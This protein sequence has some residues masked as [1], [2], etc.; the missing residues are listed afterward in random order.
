MSMT[1][2]KVAVVSE[3]ASPL[4]A[5]GGVDAGGQNVHV[6]ALSRALARR[7]HTI[8][9]YTRRDAI[10]L[11][12]QVPLD[13]GVTVEHVPA[14]PAM[15]I[16]K[17]QLLPYMG[18]FGGYLA[19]AWAADPPDIVHAH[20]WMSGLAALDGA[21]NL[22]LPVI[23]TYH[24]LG[25]VKRRHQGAADT[26]P[27]QRIAHEWA[28]GRRCDHIIATC[29]DEVDELVAMGVPRSR[30]TVVACGVDPDHFTPDGPVAARSDR[31][32]LL[33]VGRLVARKGA[34]TSIAALA[35]IPNAELV[36]AGGPPAGRLASD[37][38]A[39]RLRGLAEQSGVGNRVKLIGGIPPQRMPSLLRSAEL[40]LAPADY[41]PF[42]IV[43]LEAMSCQIPVVAT[44]VGGHLD[45]IADRTT[46]RLVSLGDPGELAAAVRELLAD[47][48]TRA[49]YG[50]E[51]RRRV[52]TRYS[53]TSVAEATEATYQDVLALAATR[54]GAA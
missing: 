50:A 33:Q 12:E 5:L 22:D 49:A 41:E 15:A 28:I 2:M 18:E 8:T 32:R 37:P 39:R 51:G 30:A 54:T 34:D 7:G 17:D 29:R 9:I 19:E 10:G 53:W 35:E 1:P 26:S 13:T 25:T 14:G 6:A 3:H 23:Q 36:I 24:A 45:T 31:P 48:E 47:P 40:V 44:A 21:A 38:E 11:A 27:S 20:F 42:G 46:G 16:P 43:P 52:L 4:A